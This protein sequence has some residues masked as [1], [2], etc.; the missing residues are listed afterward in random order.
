MIPIP[1][2][3]AKNIQ[4]VQQR[5]LKETDARVETVTEGEEFQLHRMGHAFD[6]IWGT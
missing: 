4:L 3:V 5:R 1:G 2:H 6:V